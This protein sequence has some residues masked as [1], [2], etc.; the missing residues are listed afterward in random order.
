MRPSP[1]SDPPIRPRLG[2]SGA[3]LLLPP[4]PSPRT[5]GPLEPTLPV[6]LLSPRMSE[7][8]KCPLP[9]AMKS[10]IDSVPPP[11]NAAV[12]LNGP[13][14][15]LLA[16]FPQPVQRMEYSKLPNVE[17]E[18]GP[19]FVKPLVKFVMVMAGF[20]ETSNTKDSPAPVLTNS[21]PFRRVA[22]T[23]TLLPVWVKVTVPKGLVP[24]PLLHPSW[25]SV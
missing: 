15:G 3:L 17:A 23:L 5:P 20:P 18:A 25:L 10:L 22:V 19:L 6:L 12:K 2:G 21:S 14:S 11:V 24:Q 4:P 8:K 16:P 7:A 1:S 13:G 9:L